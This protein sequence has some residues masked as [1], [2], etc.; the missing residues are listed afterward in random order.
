MQNYPCVHNEAIH[1][2][3]RL[4]TEVIGKLH[5][6]AVLSSEKEHPH[7][8]NGRKD[9]LRSHSAH[10]GEWKNLLLPGGIQ[11]YVVQRVS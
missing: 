2:K 3:L 6:P 8:L 5:A 10:L 4:Q 9:G 1:P 11:R 7:S